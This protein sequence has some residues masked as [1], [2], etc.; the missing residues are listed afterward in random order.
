MKRS[1]D[2]FCTGREVVCAAPPPVG[3]A[4]EIRRLIQGSSPKT[5]FETISG[6]EGSCWCGSGV[7]CFGLPPFGKNASSSREIDAAF[8]SLLQK[9]ADGLMVSPDPLFDSRRV[10]LVTLTTHHR[11]PTVY[12][13]RE[14]VEIGAER[15][16]C[17]EP[18]C[19]YWTGAVGEFLIDGIERK[20]RIEGT[21][22]MPLHTKLT[23]N[24]GIS[25]PILLAPMG[26]ASGGTLAKAV[27]EAG[28]LGIIGFG[29]GNQERIDQEFRAA[30]N[31]R[32]GCGFI[33]WSL[34]R[35]PHLL[36][37]ALDH[38]PVAIM[39][40]FAD[41]GPFAAAIK[42]AG[43]ALI[44]QVQTVAQAM[45]AV[46][47]GTDII[48]AQGTEAGGHGATR[49]T[50]ALVPA[51]VDA[52][53]KRNDEIVVVAAGGIADGRGLAAALML[54]AQGA[55]LRTRFLPSDQAPTSAPAK[56]KLGAARGDDTVRT[57]VFDIVRNLDWPALYTGR[58]LQNAFSRQWHGRDAELEKSLPAEAQRYTRAAEANDLDTAVV[59]AGECV[60]LI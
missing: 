46:D 33:T 13:F 29:Y 14:N 15:S 19:V 24:L 51:V 47:I 4:R 35:Q 10:Q 41:A 25:H 3:R 34:A 48:V 31:A 20:P 21:N 55:P 39:L 40:S 57:R 38:K 54:G 11:L 60:D 2:F 52:V 27:S 23:E 42:D 7:A 22:S 58:A 1:T 56:A 37:R 16:L 18:S 6:G 32:V 44:S 30:G 59:F 17:L 36:A 53:R 49:S 43:A 26:T 12:P 5:R 28:G 8:V 9:R 50:L 45:E